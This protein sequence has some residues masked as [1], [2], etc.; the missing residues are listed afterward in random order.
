[1]GSSERQRVIC[2]PSSL[3]FPGSDDPSPGTWVFASVSTKL[4]CLIQQLLFHLFQSSS[5]C[6]QIFYLEESSARVSRAFHKTYRDALCSRLG[7][8]ATVEG[9]GQ[10]H[11][12]PRSHYPFD[13]GPCWSNKRIQEATPELSLN[14][15]DPLLVMLP[16]RGQTHQA[17]LGLLLWEGRNNMPRNGQGDILNFQERLLLSSS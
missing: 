15:L 9:F 13:L 7:L 3:Y 6:T 2:V 4:V 11:M 10:E 1:M 12:Q 17:V 8:C 5:A 14:P 16:S